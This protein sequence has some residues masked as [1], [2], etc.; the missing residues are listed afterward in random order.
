MS[1]T[2][3]GADRTPLNPPD[4]PLEDQVLE[5]GGRRSPDDQ[6]DATFDAADIGEAETGLTG[7]EIYQGYLEAGVDPSGTDES[8]DALTDR[9]LRSGETSDPF[10]RRRRGADVRPAGRPAG[11]PV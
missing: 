4:V 10:H 2:E 11:R 7:T 9:E 3:R 5:L 6:E 8:V 1:D